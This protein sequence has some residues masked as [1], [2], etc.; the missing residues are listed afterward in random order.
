MASLVCLVAPVLSDDAER[1]VGFPNG[2]ARTAYPSVPRVTI[3]DN[4]MHFPDKIRDDDDDGGFRVWKLFLRLWIS[5]AGRGK[6]ETEKEGYTLHTAKS[7]YYYLRLEKKRADAMRSR[8]LDWLTFTSIQYQKVITCESMLWRKKGS[9]VGSQESG[10]KM[11]G[12]SRDIPS[13]SD[14]SVYQGCP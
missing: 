1:A 9:G 7:G 14:T 8:R 6:R 5:R 3:I 10:L 11:A 13:S 4:D 12:T 2:G